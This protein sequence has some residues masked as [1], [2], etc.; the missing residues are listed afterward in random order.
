M[1]L[2]AIKVVSTRSSLSKY[3]HSD[4]FE[5]MSMHSMVGMKKLESGDEQARERVEL[6]RLF[7]NFHYVYFFMF[8]ML[9]VPR[10]I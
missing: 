6:S 1:A 8:N 3:W 7:S 5:Q 2:L 4:F 10:H 9:S